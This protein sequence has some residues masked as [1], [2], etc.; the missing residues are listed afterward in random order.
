[1]TDCK[2]ILFCF[3]IKIT[4]MVAEIYKIFAIFILDSTAIRKILNFC[5]MH[6]I[7]LYILTN[8]THDFR[9]KCSVMFQI[10]WY[11]TKWFL[12]KDI[13]N[14]FIIIMSGWMLHWLLF[15]WNDRISSSKTYWFSAKSNICGRV[16]TFF[17]VH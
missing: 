9:Y 3:Q 6:I 10:F 12:L 16:E 4:I 2:E 1:M 8:F 5:N 15:Q 17:L 13:W 14:I 11:K 7:P